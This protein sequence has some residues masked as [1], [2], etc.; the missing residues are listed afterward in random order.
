MIANNVSSRHKS[1]SYNGSAGSHDF[2]NNVFVDIDNENT[3][4]S[5]NATFVNPEP[6]LSCLSIKKAYLC[7]AA[8]DKE[9]EDKNYEPNW[10]Y[11][12]VKIKLP[13]ANSYQTITAN[14]V[15]Y[16][17]RNEHFVNASYVCFKDITN[18]VSSLNSAYGVYQI[19]NVKAKKGGLTSNEG[20]NTGTS[21]GGQIVFYIRKPCV[22]C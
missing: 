9:E 16:R 18:Q 10:N 4:N 19:A 8:A 6:S 2:T 22:T 17:V 13:G 5:S 3:F 7:W 11:N 14:Q 1:D 12:Q 15:I 20:N 21:R